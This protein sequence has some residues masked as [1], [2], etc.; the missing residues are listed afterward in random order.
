MQSVDQR[1]RSDAGALTRVVREHCAVFDCEGDQLL[2][3]V[4]RPEPS[5]RRGVVI[6]VGGPQYRAGSHRQ[7]TLLARALAGAG[8]PAFRFDYRGMGDSSGAQREFDS[9][10]ADIDAA[11]AEFRRQVPDLDEIVL[12][13]LCD[14][15][16][17]TMMFGRHRGRIAGMVVVNPW[18]RSDTT[19]ARSNLKHYYPR[20][21][22]QRHFWGKLLSGRLHVLD[23]AVSIVATFL[24]AR[25][26]ADAPVE[27]IVRMHAGMSAFDGNTLLILSGNDLVAKEF[28]AL[29]SGTSWKSVLT[30]ERTS[31]IELPEADHTL[32]REKWRRE[33]EQ[34][35]VSWL[36]SW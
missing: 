15:A 9:I 24:R 18:V 20:R 3:I 21:L 17:A 1:Q 25:R 14:G 5:R 32:S 36:D 28:M 26:V 11:I 30:N 31:Q 34:F 22:L 29:A 33:V 8:F 19:L 2:G 13:G 23:T 6:V 27:S 12:W 35:T 7:F 16:A 4:S 10:D